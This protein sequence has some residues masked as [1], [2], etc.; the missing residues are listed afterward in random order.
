[1]WKAELSAAGVR[2]QHA[3]AAGPPEDVTMEELLRRCEPYFAGGGVVIEQP[4][5]PRLAEGMI[6]VYLCHD[7]IVGFA[8]Q[9]PRGLLPPEVAS[10]L[11]TEKVFLRRDAEA[12]RGLR[13]QMESVWVSELQAAVRV[14]RVSLPV[15]WDADF[16]YG[17][18]TG[19]GEDTYVLIE[20]NA[21]STFAFPEHAM[22]AVAR[23][24]LERI[25]S[26]TRS[27]AH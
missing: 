13:E 22:P 18:K 7:E 10:R 27:A 2:V 20:I 24:A 11:P 9:Y 17:P 23:A 3:E 12:F 6:R 14:D 8:H 26:G 4:F 25:R 19:A 5:Q 21:S 16:L 1:V 15:I